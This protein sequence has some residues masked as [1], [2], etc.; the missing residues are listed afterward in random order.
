MTAWLNITGAGAWASDRYRVE[1][2]RPLAA[3]Q[4]Y[5]RQEIKTSEDIKR[6]RG[7][8][9]LVRDKCTGDGGKNNKTPPLGTGRVLGRRS[10]PPGREVDG[11]RQRQE[12]TP[13]QENPGSDRDLVIG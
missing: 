10:S 3:A 2:P 13:V 8:N 4:K 11:D 12:G 1:S 6:R 9:R 7:I 5:T